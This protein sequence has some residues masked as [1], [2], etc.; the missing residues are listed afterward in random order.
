[1]SKLVDTTERTIRK[2][3]DRIPELNSPTLSETEYCETVL[4]ALEL[5]QEGLEMRLEELR[6]EE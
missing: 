2:A 4:A 3:L 6:K 5:I 1:M